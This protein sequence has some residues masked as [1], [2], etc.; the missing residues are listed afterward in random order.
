[1]LLTIVL[2]QPLLITQLE[3]EILGNSIFLEI[4][5]AIG[6]G[7]L[8]GTFT[9]LTPGI[10]I[11]MVNSV[12]IS[13]YPILLL[14]LT[15]TQII[16]FIVSM[17]IT[18]TFLDSLPSIFLGAPD[19]ATV[20]AVAPGHRYLLNGEGIKAFKLTLM[21]S[22]A[23]VIYS[24][25]S[26]IF[27]VKFISLIYPIL[28][29]SVGV[30][31]II[32]SIW[33]ILSSKKRFQ[34]LILFSL[35]GLLGYIVLNGKFQQPLLPLLSGM[36][37]LSS[38]LLSIM[39]KQKL[40]KQKPY[41]LKI[42]TNKT[43]IPITLTIGEISGL[44]TAIFPGIGSSFAAI[45]GTKIN[46]GLDKIKKRIKDKL[47]LKKALQKKDEISNNDLFMILLGSVNTFNF[48]LSI[49]MAF[50][51]N[52]ARN[53]SILTI[54]NLT[55]RIDIKLMIILIVTSIIVSSIVFFYSLII[56]KLFVK[57]VESINYTALSIGIAATIIIITYYFSSNTGLIILTG[58]TA[59]GIFS[60]FFKVRKTVLMSCL[61][62]PVIFWLI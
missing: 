54:L 41:D 36:F 5:V 47:M 45:I 12:I 20:L 61:I 15:L 29:P 37:G 46:D 4:I 27:V 22:F 62:L 53:G 43:R 32:T 48:M 13:S 18:H 21:G 17:S 6:L 56:L 39:N 1:M 33:L 28:K 16:I 24:S 31:L 42:G 23:A 55:K 57:S 34:S 44:I 38:I 58:S 3:H 26:I 60:S 9:G 7:I 14:K 8:F 40:P 25:L 59:I 49:P 11:N 2:S 19:E 30:I 52:K 35:S 50:I 10:H 51:A